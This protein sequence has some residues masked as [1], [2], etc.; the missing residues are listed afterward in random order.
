MRGRV[1]G[2]ALPGCALTFRVKHMQTLQRQ[3]S[4][5]T[6]CLSLVSWLHMWQMHVHMKHTG[7]CELT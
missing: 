5:T 6:M 3:A 7:L 4:D 1:L 2:P